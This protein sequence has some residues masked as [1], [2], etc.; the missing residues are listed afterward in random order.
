MGSDRYVKAIL[1]VAV[2]AW[3]VVLNVNGQKLSAEWLRPLSLVTTVVVFAAIAFNW[4]HYLL[5]KGVLPI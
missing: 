4:R 3:A 1:Y 2:A 5:C